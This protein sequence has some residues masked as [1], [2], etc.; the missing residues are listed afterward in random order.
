MDRLT[1]TLLAVIAIGVL[2]TALN[3][4]IKPVEVEASALDDIKSVLYG[5]K[6]ELSKIYLHLLYMPS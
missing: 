6:G 5:I 1:T 4:W 2:M 3:P